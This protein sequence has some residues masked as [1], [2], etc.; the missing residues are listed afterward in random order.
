MGLTVVLGH[1]QGRYVRQRIG[2]RQAALDA[3]QAQGG[4]QAIGGSGVK[5]DDRCLNAVRQPKAARRVHD[6]G[7]ADTIDFDKLLGVAGSGDA[8]IVEQNGARDFVRGAAQ[9]RDADLPSG[10]PARSPIEV[11]FNYQSDGRLKVRV[12]VPQTKQ[13]FETEIVRENGLS[14]EHMDAWR[15]YI[16]GQKPTEYR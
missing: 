10:L 16:S 5:A 12:Q 6:V 14:K 8:G 2:Q 15:E 4:I 3:K 9:C 13:H 7:I 1:N 11:N